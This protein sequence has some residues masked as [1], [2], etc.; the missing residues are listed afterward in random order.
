MNAEKLAQAANKAVGREYRICLK[1]EICKMIGLAYIA[2]WLA[3]QDESILPA[4]SKTAV[5]AI[6]LFNAMWDC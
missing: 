6:D 3:N 2:Q 5:A 1:N 4:A